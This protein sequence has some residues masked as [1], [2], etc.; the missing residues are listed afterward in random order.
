MSF[1]VSWVAA[2]V[3]VL[4]A[5][6]IGMGILSMPYWAVWLI[7]KNGNSQNGQ[8]VSGASS[9]QVINPTCKVGCSAVGNLFF[10]R[11]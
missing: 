3:V 6:V 1:G 7:A 4:A 10:P 8:P 5:L 2:F 9:G 11:Q